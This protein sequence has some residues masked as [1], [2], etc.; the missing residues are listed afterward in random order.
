[1]PK[2]PS[3]QWR[4]RKEPIL[5]SWVQASVARTGGKHD[6]NGHYGELV[7]S[8]IGTRAEAT[9]YI[10]ALHRSANHLHKWTDLH[11]GIRASVEKTGRGYKVHFHAVDKTYA[12]KYILEKYGADRSKWPY[13]PRRKVSA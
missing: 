2:G 4:R 11:V 6:E 5:D 7:I 8:D 13:D 9:E 10:R 1:M 3:P 12:Q